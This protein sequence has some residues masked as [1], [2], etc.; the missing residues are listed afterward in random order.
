MRFTQCEI[1]YQLKQSMSQAKTMEAR[2]GALLEYR[3]HLA[4]QYADRALNWSLQELGADEM[5]D[6]LVLQIDG[7]DQSK[8]R[9]PRDPMLRS[10]ASL[11]KH[12]RPRLKVH[13]LWIF[14]SLVSTK[15]V[16]SLQIWDGFWST[17]NQKLYFEYSLGHWR[18][19]T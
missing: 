6:T 1:C 4:S 11:A 13:A 15:Y 16:F 14:G 3:S 5:A 2:L 12:N 17:L 19:F 9:L 18:F 10:T 7:M 8:F